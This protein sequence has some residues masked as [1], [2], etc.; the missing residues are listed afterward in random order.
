MARGRF[1]AAGELVHSG[2]EIIG[3]LRNHCVAG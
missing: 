2:A 3:E 1:L